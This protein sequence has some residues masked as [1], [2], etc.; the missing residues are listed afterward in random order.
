MDALVDPTILEIPCDDRSGEGV[1]RV[2]LLQE[3][4]KNYT[5]TPERV[6]D[7]WVEASKHKSLFSDYTDGK[8]EPFVLLLGNPRS[9]WLEIVKDGSERPVGVAYVTD[10][11]PQFDAVAHFAFWDSVGSGREPLALFIAEWIMD[12]YSL[13]R[14]SAQI[15]PYQRGTIRFAERLGFVREGEKREAV[16]RE[17]EWHSLVLFGMT[18]NELEESLKKVW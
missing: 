14:L 8:L 6:R 17:G 5:L 4:G 18:K 15:P 2:R 10:I 16:V 13:H 7:L 12:R 3:L 9:M 1:Y 11:L